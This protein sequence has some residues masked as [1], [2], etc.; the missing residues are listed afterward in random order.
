MPDSFSKC[1][2]V[3]ILKKVNLDPVIPQNYRPVTVSVVTS[4]L[5]EYHMLEQ[6][7]G[8]KFHPGQFGFIEHRGTSMATSLANDVVIPNMDWRILFYSTFGIRKCLLILSG[9]SL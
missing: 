5:L 9:I 8:H 3:P 6:W 7:S 1:T 4:K 2:L